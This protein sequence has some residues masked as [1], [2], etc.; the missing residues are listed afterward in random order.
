MKYFFRKPKYPIIINIDGNLICGKTSTTLSRRLEKFDYMHK[1]TYP[2]IDGTG[3]GWC[4]YPDRW[5]LSPVTM[6]RNWTKQEIITL[7]NERKNK[8]PDDEPYSSR[9]LS[10]KP[11]E[12]IINEIVELLNK[13]RVRR[14]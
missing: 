1:K 6:K 5:L 9:S 10:N 14:K 7:Y 2:A 3:E 13:R 11:K 8:Q 12:R 4:F